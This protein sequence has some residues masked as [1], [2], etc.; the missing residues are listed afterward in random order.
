MKMFNLIHANL[1]NGDIIVGYYIFIANNSVINPDLLFIINLVLYEVLEL[2]RYHFSNGLII[3][4]N[5]I[6]FFKI[7]IVTH[8]PKKISDET[9]LMF[10]ILIT[11]PFNKV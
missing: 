7:L 4:T 10:L 2:L 9:S 5:I 6:Q 3:N 11:G 1:S 8:T